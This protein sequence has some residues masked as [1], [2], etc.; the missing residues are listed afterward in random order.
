MSKIIVDLIS[1]SMGIVLY[2]VITG[3]DMSNAMPN[4]YW[5]CFGGAY[6]AIK[7]KV[8]ECNND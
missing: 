1:L 7:N 3:S 2:H 4:I 8:W 6:V 5:C